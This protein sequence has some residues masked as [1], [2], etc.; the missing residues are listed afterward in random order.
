MTTTARFAGT[1][2]ECEQGWQP[3]EQIRIGADQV[4][5]HA[6][7]P[8]DTDDLSLRPGESVCTTCWLTACDCQEG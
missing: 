4:W 7:C 5:Q 1:C 6:V 3:G 8:D 2:P